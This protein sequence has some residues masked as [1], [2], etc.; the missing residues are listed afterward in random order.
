M[1]ALQ[2]KGCRNSRETGRSGQTQEGN[3]EKPIQNPA[4]PHLHHLAPAV[5]NKVSA[6]EH[7]ITPYS[8]SFTFMACSLS[9]HTALPD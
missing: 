9:E 5:Y 4:G 2:N 1:L 6:L 3:T 8:Q 7:W